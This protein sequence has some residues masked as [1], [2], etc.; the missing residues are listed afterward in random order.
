VAPFGSRRDKTLRKSSGQWLDAHEHFE[1][2]APEG[3]EW[4][5]LKKTSPHEVSLLSSVD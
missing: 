2:T 5:C 4:Q 3:L 1:S